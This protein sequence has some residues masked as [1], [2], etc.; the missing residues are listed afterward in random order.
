MIEFDCEHCS[1][2]IS[3]APEQTEG[4]LFCPA[5]E[6]EVNLPELSPELQTQLAIA[7]AQAKNV[8]K[9]ELDAEKAVEML[10]QPDSKETRVWKERLAES[11]QVFCFKEYQEPDEATVEKAKEEVENKKGIKKILNIFS[12]K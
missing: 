3:I 5:C 7:K 4:E 1:T 10:Q 11:F 6:L 2:H 9:D 12:K 8:M